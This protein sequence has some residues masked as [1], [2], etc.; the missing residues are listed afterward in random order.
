MSAPQDFSALAGQLLTFIPVSTQPLRHT[1]IRRALDLVDNFL[2]D[3]EETVLQPVI[4]AL[5]FALAQAHLVGQV[6]AQQTTGP[7]VTVPLIC[8]VQRPV[9]LP[10]HGGVIHRSPVRNVPPVIKIALPTKRDREDDPEEKEQLDQLAE[11]ERLAQLA[12]VG[13]L[14]KEAENKKR[15]MAEEE[16]RLVAQRKKEKKEAAAAL[17]MQADLLEKE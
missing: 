17:R 8:V 3:Y 16:E 13:R 5:M 14:A 6:R 1:M 11:N 4:D 9:T 15:L 2:D 7:I 10:Y 12:E